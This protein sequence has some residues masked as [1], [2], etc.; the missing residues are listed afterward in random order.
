MGEYHV[1][2]G[3]KLR[4]ELKIGGGK[5]A[6]LPILASV[7]LNSGKSI[8]HNCPLISD[9]FISIKMLE[10]IGCK[11]KLEGRS[12][13]VDSGSAAQYE[14]PESLVREMRSSF[15]F[16]GGVLG[17]FRKVKIS[18]PGGCDSW[19]NNGG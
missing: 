12:M 18:Y 17:R 2:G 10:A 8:I 7:V 4:G 5:N 3:K 16:L 1:H 6:I 14:L 13:I 11:V 15:I 9:T 19:N